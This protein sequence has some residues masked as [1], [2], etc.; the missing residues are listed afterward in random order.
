M[1]NDS[2]QRKPQDY[3]L[4]RDLADDGTFR[5]R[6]KTGHPVCVA[7]YGGQR[8]FSLCCTPGRNYQKY[9]VWNLNQFVRSLA[10]EDA[11]RFSLHKFYEDL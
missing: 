2:F 10:L 9:M 4:L 8:S 1:T 7:C 3:E 5:M 11:P 6:K